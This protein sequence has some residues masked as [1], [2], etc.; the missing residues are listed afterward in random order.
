MEFSSRIPYLWTPRERNLSAGEGEL[1]LELLTLDPFDND[2]DPNRCASSWDCAGLLPKAGDWP[3]A[4]T[5]FQTSY[6]CLKN[7]AVSILQMTHLPPADILV[8]SGHG[9][10]ATLDNGQS[11]S[12]L[13]TRT[14]V[15]SQ[16]S[17]GGDPNFWPGRKDIF[18]SGGVTNAVTG[19]QTFHLSI[20]PAFVTRYIRLKPGAL[21]YLNACMTGANDSLA[22]AFRKVGAGV[23]FYHSG[24]EGIHT[25]YSSRMMALTMSGMLGNQPSYAGSGVFA[26]SGHR[27]GTF[28]CPGE[29]IAGAHR[30]MEEMI[31]AETPYVK[32]DKKSYFVLN[33]WTKRVEYHNT[34][35]S[36]YGDPQYTLFPGVRGTMTLFSQPSGDQTPPPPQA[37]SVSLC[38]EDG[39][40]VATATPDDRYE[41]SFQLVPPGDYTL[42]A[43]LGDLYIGFSEAFSVEA[44]RYASVDIQAAGTLTGR[45]TDEAGVPLPNAGVSLYEKGALFSFCQT[46]EAGVFVIPCFPGTGYTLECSLEG[47][48]THTR[49]LIST[50]P[51]S[52][53]AREQ[54]LGAI[55]L[56]K[57][58]RSPYAELAESYLAQYGL[59]GYFMD[60][61]DWDSRYWHLVTTGVSY[62]RLVDFNGDGVAELI[63]GYNKD[64]PYS[65]E[66]YGDSYEIKVF[67]IQNGAAVEL[68]SGSPVVSLPYEVQSVK[69][70]QVDGR[71]Y[72]WAGHTGNPT[73]LGF[74]TC[75]AGEFAPLHDLLYIANGTSPCRVDGEEAEQA[76]ARQALDQWVE[77][78]DLYVLNDGNAPADSHSPDELLAMTME[79][80]KKL[81]VG[82]KITATGERA[83]AFAAYGE[84]LRETEAAAGVLRYET[85]SGYATL[86]GTWLAELVDFNGDGMEELVVSTHEL[87]DEGVPLME[88]YAWSGG[89]AGLV[90]SGEAFSGGDPGITGLRLL[91][92]D[93]GCYLAE[94]YSGYEE[95]ITYLA[96]DGAAFTPA[97][98]VTTSMEEGEPATIDGKPL[99]QDAWH[100]SQEAWMADKT[101]EL[102][103]VNRFPG[104]NA[105]ETRHLEDIPSITQQTKW[106]LGVGDGE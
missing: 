2:G 1:T 4:L 29:A 76:A 95:N 94:G 22:E 18:F 89:R 57:K 31:R 79:T 11:I 106:Q 38:R 61:D 104:D 59:P 84:I 60:T 80:L 72:L 54:D 40:V 65:R 88:V 27:A 44:H 14:Q 49:E 68:S 74:Y 37:L 51:V 63:L 8:F 33:P 56:R 87:Q 102:Y 7:E 13:T 6:Q 45:I 64:G 55:P 15:D 34:W 23:V 78:S 58:V 75:E 69:L 90:Y 73:E 36:F 35:L 17:P 41:F 19:V 99:D 21:V 96:F 81:G 71:Y 9:G 91:K 26:L 39:T 46:D 47:Y 83:A 12:L 97:R 28:L 10:V 48:E 16:W 101:W 20:T 32:Y 5:Q 93:G 52:V 30:C 50:A 66:G 43:R 42:R 24:T 25:D 100:A 92:Y 105:T 98:R 3:E 86:R 70:S 53:T 85:G 82:P 62:A 77:S 103:Y 67:T